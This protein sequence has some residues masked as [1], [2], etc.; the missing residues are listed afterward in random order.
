[1]LDQSIHLVLLPGMDGTGT[2]FEPIKRALEPYFTLQIVSYPEH[3]VL[4]YQELERRIKPFIASRRFVLLGES[5][6][7]PLAISIAAKH[8][9]GLCG[10]ILC[11]SFARNPR[12][13]LGFLQGLLSFWFSRRI[14]P[15]ML[16]RFASPLLLGSR[17]SQSIEAL[18]RNALRKV[19]AAVMARRAQE[20][21][22]IDVVEEL[23]S[24]N[25]PL[26]YLQAMQDRVVPVEA[27]K[28][29]E[30]AYGS[31]KLVKIE[32]PHCLLQVSPEP[33]ARAI[34]AFC[35]QLG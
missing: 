14:P 1:M 12:P 11:C 32:G 10:V 2:L 8:P 18:L 21:L 19:S 31:V 24:L 20:V 35:E 17:A 6:S 13:T 34:R 9:P 28:L 27:A 29:I 16:S 25:V 15:H 33:S 7:G 5:F 30:Q 23:R 4:G 26:M 3:E 22:A